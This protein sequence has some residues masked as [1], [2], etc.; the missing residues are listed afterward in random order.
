MTMHHLWEEDLPLSHGANPP[1]ILVARLSFGMDL[2]PNGSLVARIG[3]VSNR[4]VF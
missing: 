1:P 2:R 4:I 3:S